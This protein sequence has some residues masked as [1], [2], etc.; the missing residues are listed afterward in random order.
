MNKP[1]KDSRVDEERRFAASRALD[2]PPEQ[3]DRWEACRSTHRFMAYENKILVA[4]HL[5]NGHP[6]IVDTLTC[7]HFG[8]HPDTGLD[9]FWRNQAGKDLHVTHTPA[10]VAP[11]CFM[12]H[13]KSTNIEYVEHRLKLNMRF[14]ISYRT[15]FNPTSMEEGVNYLLEKAVFDTFRWAD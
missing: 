1:S 3:Q 14:S 12:W 9:S 11:G 6:V 13:N 5:V 10:E 15:M 8:Y 4:Y 7:T 2:L